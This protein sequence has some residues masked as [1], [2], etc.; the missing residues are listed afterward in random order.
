[1][2]Q[3]NGVLFTR[4]PRQ[5]KYFVPVYLPTQAALYFA[6]A[7]DRASLPAHRQLSF[8]REAQRRQVAGFAICRAF[9]SLRA[10]GLR[11]LEAAAHSLRFVQ[12]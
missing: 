8:S 5:Y 2:W 7:E 9:Y 11:R 6:R 10:I 4:L 12:S 3:G 1:L